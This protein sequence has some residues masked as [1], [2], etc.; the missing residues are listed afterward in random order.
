M[1]RAGKASRRESATSSAFAR[2]PGG[3]AVLHRRARLQGQRLARRFHVLPALQR[4][5]PPPRLPA[6]PAVPQPRRLRHARRR[7]HDA[8]RRAAPE[9]GRRDAS[10]APAATPPATTPSAISSRRTASR[11]NT[12]PSSRRSTT[13]HGSRRSTRPVRGSW[14]SGAS[15]SAAR[16]PCRIPSRTRGLFQPAEA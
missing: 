2:P 12:P 15:A 13:P 7:R 8:R 11:S 10:G 9:A 16:R 4:M 6:R 3:G 1:R 14:T 5:A